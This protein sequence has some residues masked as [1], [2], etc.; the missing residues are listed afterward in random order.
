MVCNRLRDDVGSEAYARK[1]REIDGRDPETR[2]LLTRL[3]L[4]RKVY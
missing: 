1:A 3:C 2:R 4:E